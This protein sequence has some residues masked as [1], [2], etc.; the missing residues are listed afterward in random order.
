MQT[1]AP[2]L[3]PARKRSTAGRSSW[4]S[5]VTT[6]ARPPQR[7]ASALT[8][9]TMSRERGDQE[10]QTTTMVV[11]RARSAS[12]RRPPPRQERLTSSAR[13][14]AGDR[15]SNARETTR[16]TAALRSDAE[17]VVVMEVSVKAGS[18]AAVRK[19]GEDAVPEAFRGWTADRPLTDDQQQLASVVDLLRAVAALPD[20]V[21]ERGQRLLFDLVVKKQEQHQA[22]LFAIHRPSSGTHTLEQ[23]CV[24]APD[25]HPALFNWGVGLDISP[26]RWAP[27]RSHFLAL[28]NASCSLGTRGAA[29]HLDRLAF[30]QIPMV[31]GELEHRGLE[32]PAA[33]VQAAHHGADR[34]VQDLGD[35]LVGEPFEVGQQHHHPVIRRQLVERLLHVL[36]EHILE[37]LL[38][39]V[40]QLLARRVLADLVLERLLDLGEVA[41]GRGLLLLAVV[42]DEGVLHDLEQPR[43][44]VGPFLELVIVAVGLQIGLLHEV[45]G[46]LGIA[47]HPIGRIVE[48]VY[49][50]H[51]RRFEVPPFLVVYASLCHAYPL[52]REP[53]PAPMHTHRRCQRFEVRKRPIP[54]F[55][56]V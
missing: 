40:L 48:S 49:E 6:R 52:Q 20:V 56:S 37:Q 5:T 14:A 33:A 26:E 22:D 24:T 16:T 34:N 1:G 28:P 10:A 46:V 9:S 44:E 23:S 31:A 4:K 15:A 12:P 43:L 2:R 30:P 50:R 11:P 38:L 47:G 21:V 39:G 19:V 41:E 32:Q 13:E 35:L 3:L 42:V 17:E 7:L 51:R 53:L 25:V 45:L 36:V 54:A 18:A 8:R 29:A 27:G 55:Q